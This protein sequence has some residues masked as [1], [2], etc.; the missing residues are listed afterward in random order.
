MTGGGVREI[1]LHGYHPTVLQNEWIVERLVQQAWEMGL[2]ELTII[3]G[4]GGS[5]GGPRPFANTNTG[6]LGITVRRILRGCERQWMYAKF[7]VSRAGSTTIRLKPNPQ[8]SRSEF[9]ELPDPR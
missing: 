5:R 8:P 7:D 2:S 1:D 9:D 3:H 6:Y 4:H